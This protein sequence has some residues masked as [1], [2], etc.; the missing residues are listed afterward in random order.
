MVLSMQPSFALASRNVADAEKEYSLAVD[1]YDQVVLPLLASNTDVRRWAVLSL[2]ASGIE[3]V[4][5]GIEG[6]LKSVL[7]EVDG[8]VHGGPEEFHKALLAQAA[9]KTSDREPII[10]EEAYSLLNELR[11]FRHVERNV[12]IH[13]FRADDVQADFERL[14]AAFPIV[15]SDIKNFIEAMSSIDDTNSTPGKKF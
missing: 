1:S 2:I 15:I 14:K 8:G 11:G 6:A 4:Y 9:A 10:S 5:T 13:R 3:H 7:N 12:Y